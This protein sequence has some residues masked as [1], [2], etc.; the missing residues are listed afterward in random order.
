MNINGK[1]NTLNRQ[2]STDF[3]FCIRSRIYCKKR[4]ACS[5]MNCM[6]QRLMYDEENSF[7][8]CQ[9]SIDLLHL[10]DKIDFHQIIQQTGFIII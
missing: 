9:A 7:E 6:S 2:F 3:F 1:I 4:Y 10:R 8:G 5:S